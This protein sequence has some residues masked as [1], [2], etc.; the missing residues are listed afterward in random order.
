MLEDL[1]NSE[2]ILK[3]QEASSTLFRCIKRLLYFRQ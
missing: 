3:Y 1:R 2:S